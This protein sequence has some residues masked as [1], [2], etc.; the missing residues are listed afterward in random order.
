ML[1]ISDGNYRIRWLTLKWHRGWEKSTTTLRQ[2]AQ[3]NCVSFRT[4]GFM[5]G[6]GPGKGKGPGFSVAFIANKEPVDAEDE[7]Q[8]VD[9]SGAQQHHP[10]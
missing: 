3:A 6:L 8:P 4:I 2:L 5:G 1:Y 9:S 10:N 7:C